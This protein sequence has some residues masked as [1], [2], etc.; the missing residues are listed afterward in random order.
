MQ[1]EGNRAAIRFRVRTKW[2]TYLLWALP[3]LLV[4]LTITREVVLRVWGASTF[5]GAMPPLQIDSEVSFANW[6]S[7]VLLILTS[8]LLFLVGRAE[9]NIRLKPYWYAL[10][11]IFVF[12]SMDEGSG[13]HE[14]A[15]GPMAGFQLPGPPN[16]YWV[17]PYGIAFAALVAVFLP[18]VV[19]LPARLRGVMIAAAAIYVGS[20]VGLEMAESHLVSHYGATDPYYLFAAQFQE[21][22]EMVGITIFALGLIQTLTS[23]HQSVLIFMDSDGT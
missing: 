8:I 14:I 18:F 12:L 2:L 11:L 20:A 3:I 1:L 15:S 17:V 7:S 19:S 9:S 10:A 21:V 16:Y 4:A 23:A 6:Y 13:L 5:L 22:G